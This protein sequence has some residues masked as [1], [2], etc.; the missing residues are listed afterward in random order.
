MEYTIDRILSEVGLDIGYVQK[1]SKNT[2]QDYKY[3]GAEE[4]LSRANTALFSRGVSISSSAEVEH[5]N[6]TQYTEETK[7]GL[8]TKFRS[9]AV[10]RLRLTF[11]YADEQRTVEGLGSATDLGDKAVMKA[12]TAALKYCLA[13]AF[14]ISWGDDPEADEAVDREVKAQPTSKEAPKETQG[15]EYF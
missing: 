5:F 12:N 15:L 6:V 3:A 9:D 1:K 13:N 14:L 2:A 7:F 8:K 11:H 10:V 4:V